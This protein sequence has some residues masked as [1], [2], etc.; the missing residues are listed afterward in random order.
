MTLRASATFRKGWDRLAEGAA[1]A[2]RLRS[3]FNFSRMRTVVGAG[4]AN[5]LFPPSCASCAAELDEANG[6]GRDVRLCVDCLDEMGIFSE[7]MCTRCG[8]PV[9]G[10][11]AHDGQVAVKPRVR[12]GC[13][14]CGGRKLWFDETVAL[15]HY[16]GRLR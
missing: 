1:L 3:H 7:P 6:A 4:L 15:G 12:A 13:Y 2:G 10:I 9:P 5:L 11:V 8:A 14:R 16:D